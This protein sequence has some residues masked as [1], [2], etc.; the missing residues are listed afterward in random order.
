MLGVQQKTALNGM[1]LLGS[2]RGFR[3]AATGRKQKC[4]RKKAC[5]VS[6]QISISQ[7]TKLNAMVNHSLA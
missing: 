6:H 1:R 2:G 5:K 3:L 4:Q 7:A